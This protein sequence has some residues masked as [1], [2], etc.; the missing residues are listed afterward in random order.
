MNY[1]LTNLAEGPS[2]FQARD[3]YAL[4][5]DSVLYQDSAICSQEGYARESLRP[6]APKINNKVTEAKYFKAFPVPAQNTLN[7]SFSELKSAA[8]VYVYDMEGRLMISKNINSNSRNAQLELSQVP[9][10]VYH[11]L[12]MN[13][14]RAERTK[15]SVIK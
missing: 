1:N 7:L 6:F 14:E 8:S 12:L 15:I 3:I 10:G 4:L 5:V 13:N 2:A 11:V 9:A